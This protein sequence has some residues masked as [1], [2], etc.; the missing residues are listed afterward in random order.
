MNKIKYVLGGVILLTMA[1]YWVPAGQAIEYLAAK[2][3]VTDKKNSSPEGFSGQG[4][5]CNW[6]GWKNSFPEVRCKYNRCAR[7]RE[8]LMIKCSDGFI[9]EM[10]TNR[11]CAACDQL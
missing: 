1:A 9:T 4:I 7:R 3:T 8:V 6:S 5:P 10:K 2:E 11:V